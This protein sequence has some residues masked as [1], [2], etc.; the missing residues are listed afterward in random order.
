MHRWGLV[1]AALTTMLGASAAS[2]TDTV[3]TCRLDAS[4]AFVT[5][6]VEHV[7]GEERASDAATATAVCVSLDG[8]S[9]SVALTVSVQAFV[10]STWVTVC[11]NNASA[12]SVDGIAVVVP[13]V[14][15]CQYSGPSNPYL[16]TYHRGRATLATPSGPYDAYSAAW[17]A[18]QT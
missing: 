7:T 2:A 18:P 13:P 6:R 17:F 4:G 10:G 3:V 1:L 8:G 12:S 11:S 5:P 9:Y 16:D 14:A 15:L